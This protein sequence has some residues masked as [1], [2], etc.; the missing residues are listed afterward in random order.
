LEC[1]TSLNYVLPKCD[2]PVVCTFDLSKFGASVTIDILRAQ[3]VVIFGGVPQE[4]P[5][6][7]PLDQY[8]HDIRERRSAR[9]SAAVAN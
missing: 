4:N 3:P 1:E 9:K 2:D 5:F 6:F 7:V 8:L